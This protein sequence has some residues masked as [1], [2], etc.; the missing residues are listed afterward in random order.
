MAG[1][2]LH[3]HKNYHTLRIKCSVWNAFLADVTSTAAWTSTTAWYISTLFLA[4]EFTFNHIMSNVWVVCLAQCIL[5]RDSLGW[6]CK[7]MRWGEVMRWPGVL[8][9][10]AAAVKN[11]VRDDERWY[12]HTISLIHTQCSVLCWLVILLGTLTAGL[13]NMG[14]DLVECYHWDTNFPHLR[15]LLFLYCR[16]I[17]QYTIAKWCRGRKLWC[18]AA[19]LM[20][21]WI[22]DPRYNESTYMDR[23]SQEESAVG[24]L[25]HAPSQHGQP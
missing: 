10:A 17:W 9:T 15:P 24:Q 22:P 16:L 6:E 23:E 2:E 8:G 1:N 5:E 18:I 7:W 4:C 14:H 20:N 21:N 11:C 19:H 25:A 13:N 12:S 3:T